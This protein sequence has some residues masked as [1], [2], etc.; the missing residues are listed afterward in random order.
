M[1]GTERR[2]LLRAQDCH[3][4]GGATRAGYG[5]ALLKNDAGMCRGL[6]AMRAQGVDL[7]AKGIEPQ[8]GLL[9]LGAKGVGGAAC[10]L[11]GVVGK[12]EAQG[13]QGVGFGE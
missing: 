3:A 4:T 8:V 11:V 12:A 7:G 10:G 9:Q 6:H 5:D 13:V 1:A 2:D